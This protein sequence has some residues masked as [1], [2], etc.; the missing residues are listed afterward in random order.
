MQDDKTR[1]KIAAHLVNIEEQFL[2]DG[3]NSYESKFINIAKKVLNRDIKENLELIQRIKREMKTGKTEGKPLS[4]I[5]F[6][7]IRGICSPQYI[8][9]HLLH[10]ITMLAGLI[11]NFEVKEIEYEEKDKKMKLIESKFEN[12][13]NKEWAKED[14]QQIETEL[15]KVTKKLLEDIDEEL[16]KDVSG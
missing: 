15:K 8:S 7:L 9:P 14:Y 3:V 11:D 12:D 10:Y 13:I 2:G 1:K 4:T 5:E 6:T 16:V